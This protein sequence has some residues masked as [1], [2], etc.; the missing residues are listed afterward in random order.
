M[1]SGDR[2]PLA[3]AQ[4]AASRLVSTLA[5]AC[6]RIEVAGSIRR[7]KA[8]VGDIEI[9]AIPK[10]QIPAAQMDIFGGKVAAA[11]INLLDRLLDQLVAGKA[12]TQRPP[13]SSSDWKPLWGPKQK[14]FL[15][16]LRECDTPITLSSKLIQVDL[17]LATHD[18]WGS[19]LTIRTGPQE[20]STGI[21]VHINKV[22]QVQQKDGMLVSCNTG[23]MIPVPTEDAYFAAV[24]LAYVP[25]EKRSRY[26]VKPI[27]STWQRPGHA[28]P[29]MSEEKP[30]ERE[31]ELLT[32]QDMREL[33]LDDYIAWM[34]ESGRY[35]V[36]IETGE[37]TNPRSG[38]ALSP[39]LNQAGYH[40]VNL[41]YN[42][43]VVRRVKV[44][45]MV[46]VKKYGV[47]AVV[48]KH[49]AHLDS[50][51]THNHWSNLRPMTPT[52]HMA[53][54]GICV[55]SYPHPPKTE[56]PPCVRCGDPDGPYS[57]RRSPD[58]IS[59]ARFGIEGQLCRRCYGALQE[60]E[61]RAKAREKQVAA[62]KEEDLPPVETIKIVKI[63]TNVLYNLDV[64]VCEILRA[65]LLEK[66]G[67]AA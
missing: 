30:G 33:G 4:A 17:F 47:D 48:G 57:N 27:R 12:I 56:W 15:V 28:T 8:E 9:V 42:R 6:E 41:V 44:H 14:K 7:K 11:P 66:A 39:I 65:G 63:S 24:G 21:M 36:D 43:E 23:V 46:A 60:R 13:L 59:G 52:E 50:N 37:V 58:R 40:E 32:D 51:K 38:Q 19:I 45:R 53:Y 16:G 22:G 35:D 49:I 20:F 54:D 5:P 34:L 67:I 61:R 62:D 3:I 64:D 1:S 55:K 25:P 26:T 29:D 2:L 18:N 31:E 10:V